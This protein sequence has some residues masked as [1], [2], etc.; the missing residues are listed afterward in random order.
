MITLICALAFLAPTAHADMITADD[1]VRIPATQPEGSGNGTLNLILFSAETEENKEKGGCNPNCFDGDDA[2]TALPKGLGG[3]D[4]GL[5]A[6][7]YVT[8]A[9]KL[10]AF[11]DLNFGTDTITEMVIFL[12]LNEAN[13][14]TKAINHFL[15]MDVIL[16]PETIYGNPDPVNT[17]VAS[18]IGN[19]NVLDEGTQNYIRQGYT[20]GSLEAALDGTIIPYNMPVTYQGAGKADYVIYTGI[21]PYDY[22]TDDILLFNQSI[23]FLSNGGETKFLSGTYSGDDICLPDDPDCEIPPSPVPE[24]ATM[25]LLGVGLIGMAGFGRRKLKTK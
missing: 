10:Q 1:I 3:T 24:P 16:N 25:L 6:E 21:N 14:G 5:Y 22:E 9:G 18:N 8:T 15:L 2:N 12:D 19:P 17:D 7:S 13:E 20:G 4:E 11:Y 23:S